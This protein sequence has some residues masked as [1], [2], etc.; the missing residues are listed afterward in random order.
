MN[1]MIN[2]Y[3]LAGLLLVG[4]ILFIQVSGAF[5]STGLGGE[6][7]WIRIGH[8]QTYF[9]EWGSEIEDSGISE[10]SAAFSWDAAYGLD[11]S[12][13]RSKCMWL[14]CKNYYDANVDKLFTYKV[15][16]VGPRSGDEDRA[17]QIFED[18]HLLYGKNDH[19]IVVVDGAGATVNTLYDVLDGVDDSMQCDRMMVVRNNTAIGVT[20][21]KK[22]MAFGQQYHDDYFIYD[23]VLKNTGIIKEDGTV[24]SQTVNDFVF[25]LQYRY[26]LSGESKPNY[27]DGWGAWESTWGR[28]TVNEV[29]GTNPNATDFKMRAFYSWY[30]GNDG[31]PISFEADL[32]LPHEEE[33]GIMAA[34]K[35]AGGVTLHVDKSTADRSDDLRQPSTTHYSGSDGDETQ[36]PYSQYDE[37]FMKIRYD[38]MTSGHASPTHAAQVEA[39]NTYASLWGDDEGGIAQNTAF[40]P[41]TLAPGDS[42]HIVVAEG[43]SGIGRVK[44]REVSSKWLAWYNGTGTPELKM[45]DGTTTTDYNGYKN[46]WIETGIDSLLETFQHALDNYAAGY[47]IPQPPPP[48]DRFEVASGGDRIRLTWSDNAAS[49]PNFDGYVIYR[50]EGTVLDPE[51]VYEKIFECSGGADLVHTFDDITAARGFDYYYYIQS[52]DDGSTNDVEPGKPL[53]SSMFWTLTSVPAYLRRPAGTALEEVRVVPNPYD[54]RSRMWQFGDDSQYDRLAF[55]GLPPVCDVKVFTERGDLIWE[56]VHNDGSGDELWDSMTSSSQI[57]VSGIYILYIEVTEDV[58]D[59]ETGDLKFKKGSSV[60]R[61]FVVIR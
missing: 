59:S 30:G 8:L 44:N 29:I 43:V 3:S 10:V 46:A 45:P 34:A 54:I 38:V 50:S 36:T 49:W 14:G 27:D 47:D 57:I 19:P 22:V 5:A 23:Y 11:Q 13:L 7:K 4:M 20:V 40:G 17:Y 28:E 41:Y 26:A 1:K 51:S 24:H 56:K 58:V 16:G 42:V 18:Q 9:S 25:F 52:K 6:I 39:A 60:F 15:V 37:G 35:Y 55:Y 53:V 33:D 61:K 21:T 48:P 32:G 31:R 2:R 12:T